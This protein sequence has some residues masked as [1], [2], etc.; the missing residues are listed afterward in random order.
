M[1]L[2]VC[3]GCSAAA[4]FAGGSGS[5]DRCRLRSIAETRH[6]CQF[7]VTSQR[8]GTGLLT[9]QTE[10]TEQGTQ[11]KSF[12]GALIEQAK[13]ELARTPKFFLML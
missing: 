2:T 11:Q 13:Q 5:D 6:D 10:Q 8:T 12:E 7:T 9:E 4:R 1:W 3:A